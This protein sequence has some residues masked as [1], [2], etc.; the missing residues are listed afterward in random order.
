MSQ[1]VILF[2][3]KGAEVRTVLMDGAP[4]F[5]GKDVCERLGYANPNKAMNDHCKGVTK[6]YP[7]Q[8]PG[9]VQEVRVLSEP[10][11][12]RLMCVT[13]WKLATSGM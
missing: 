4:A 12:L 13:C 5:V 10:D 1:N 6:R 2:S 3:F 7:L 9:G 8:T 11:V